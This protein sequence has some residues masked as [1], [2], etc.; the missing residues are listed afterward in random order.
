M[1]SVETFDFSVSNGFFSYNVV[2]RRGIFMPLLGPTVRAPF[3]GS[4]LYVLP[5]LAGLDVIAIKKIN[6]F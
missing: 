4:Y 6:N 3:D 2:D 5:G 1:L